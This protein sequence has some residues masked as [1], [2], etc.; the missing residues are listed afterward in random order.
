MNNKGLRGIHKNTQSER[1]EGKKGIIVPHGKS[2]NCAC[3]KAHSIPQYSP[4]P[5][6]EANETNKIKESKRKG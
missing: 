6:E 5:R 1:R 4:P 3:V 2:V